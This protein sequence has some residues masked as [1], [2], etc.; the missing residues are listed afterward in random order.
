VG[1]GR[2]QGDAKLRMFSMGCHNQILLTPVFSLAWYSEKN[3][4]RRWSTSTNNCNSIYLQ[5]P[6]QGEALQIKSLADYQTFSMERTNLVS[7]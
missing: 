4:Y 2:T 6:N 1:L 7:S 3:H 5:E